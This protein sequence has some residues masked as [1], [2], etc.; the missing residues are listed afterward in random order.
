MKTAKRNI[1]IVSALMAALV[2]A[3]AVLPL[4]ASAL[5]AMAGPC[6]DLYW[7]LYDMQE[8]YITGE[9]DMDSNHDTW[10]EFRDSVTDIVIDEGVTSICWS[11]FNSFEKL[12]NV[13]IGN[14]VTTIDD[15]AFAWCG[16][17]TFVTIPASVESIGYCAFADC[18][19]L[20]KIQVD[21]GNPY[22]KSDDRGVLFSKDGSKL[23]KA[24]SAIAGE[25]VIPDGTE[26]IDYWAFQNCDK[27]ESVT[28]PASVDFIDFCAFD[29]CGSLE[30]FYFLGDA[31]EVPETAF[32][33]I[34]ATAYYP[35][36]NET[37]TEEMMESFDGNITWVP[38]YETAPAVMRL[39]RSPVITK[40][41]NTASG[42]KITWDSVDGAE[43][44]RV[45]VKNGGIWQ[46]IGVTEGTCF[47]YPAAKSGK[48]YSFTVRC[49]NAANNAFTSSCNT[50]GWTT[51]YLATPAITKLE[52]TASGVK[53]SWDKV[54]GAENYRVFIMTEN[55]W[56]GL[57]NTTG[58]S[59]VYTAA[60]SGKSYTF[61][62]RCV[63]ADGKRFTSSFS[64]YGK[65]I[66]YIAQ[67]RISG[68]SFDD[69]SIDITWNAVTGAEKYRVYVKTDAGWKNIGVTD[70]NSF[71]FEGAEMGKSY[72]FTLR[73]VNDANNAFTSSHSSEGWSC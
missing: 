47:T 8:L 61:T 43:K 44:Y 13:T 12:E 59:Y 67:P 37:W 54:S 58:C 22:Y 46:N 28:V 35:A 42:V 4:S 24:P 33:D 55:G 19:D 10:S 6:G 65:S 50:A 2:L 38:V 1:L 5:C 23:I 68:L 26:S 21:S 16:K 9:G 40:L 72:T 32:C 14:T 39:L 48:S 3:M 41:E 15:Y 60:E 20:Q 49:V 53:I 70:G 63:S 7:E 29:S 25:Y 66:T 11:A 73:C 34:T 71:V 31:P 64:P 45:Y 52:N 62:V 27:L 51:T 57:G 36:G 30:T 18:Y 56:M 17:L 69:G